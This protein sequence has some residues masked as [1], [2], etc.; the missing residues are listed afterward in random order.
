VQFLKG[1]ATDLE[2]NIECNNSFLYRELEGFNGKKRSGEAGHDDC[3]D[4]ISDATSILAQRVNIPNMAQA[5]SSVNLQ[6]KSP[7]S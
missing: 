6:N 7:L 1:C 2:N 4:C 3:V 5:L